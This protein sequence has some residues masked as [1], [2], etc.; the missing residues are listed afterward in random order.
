MARLIIWVHVSIRGLWHAVFQYN[1]M[2][3]VAEVSSADYSAC[4]ASNSIQSYSDQN[5][6]IA[7]TKP[8][9]RYFV[10]GTPGHCSG[11]MKLAVTVAAADA[12]APAPESP[13]AATPA[14]PGTETPPEGATPSTPA[15]TNAPATGSTS[16]AE[17]NR[18]VM[19]LAAGAAAIAGV[20]LI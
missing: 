1:M 2:H 11:G 16:G 17:N 8:G 19:G 13:S 12:T 5:T 10:C 15:A 4:S 9:T 3:T 18:L 14:A 6:K 7:L 20:A